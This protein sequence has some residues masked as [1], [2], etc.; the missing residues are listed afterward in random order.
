MGALTSKEE[1]MNSLLQS[2]I[3]NIEARESGALPAVAAQAAELYL[4]WSSEA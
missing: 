3:T 2:V 4:P 1:S